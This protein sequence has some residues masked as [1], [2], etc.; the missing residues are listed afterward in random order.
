MKYQLQ[1]FEYV[2]HKHPLRLVLLFFI[3]IILS[4][5]PQISV[6]AQDPPPELE[7]QKVTAIYE[8]TCGEQDYQDTLEVW[9]VGAAGGE[10]YA[11]AV[12]TGPTCLTVDD[13]E[14]ILKASKTFYGTFSGG[15]NGIVKQRGNYNVDLQFVDGK[16][17]EMVG[18]DYVMIVQNPEAFTATTQDCEAKINL[19]SELKP[20][21]DIWMS[22]SY[23]DLDGVPI[24]SEKIISEA[25]IINGK[26]GVMLTTWDGEAMNIELQYTC[27]D[28]N[29]H[30]TNY[31]L[32]AYQEE[33]VQAP[34]QNVDVPP[35]EVEV[36]PEDPK[37]ASPENDNT[38]DNKITQ[39]PLLPIVVIVG[40]LAIG[41]AVL[42]GTG[43]VIFGVGKA[44]GIIGG[45]P[46]K[47][48]DS[49]SVARSTPQ[50][51]VA[52]K[53]IARPTPHISPSPPEPVKDLHP[54]YPKP[55]T[56]AEMSNLKHRKA[57]MEQAIEEY[58]HDWQE[59]NKK[60][61]RL[62]KMHKK[63]LIKRMLQLGL[64]TED[65]IGI[66][67][68]TDLVTKILSEPIEDAVGKPSP[69]KETEI[70]LATDKIIN[71]MKGKLEELQGNVRYLRTEIH[72]I[73]KNLNS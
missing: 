6:W 19:P 35:E 20:G 15:P 46:Q 21:D 55:L 8:G 23:T 38:G 9:N 42:L 44:T 68:P 72:N 67:N 34:D 39:S 59:T 37:Q 32:P 61:H 66:K 62:Q 27:P 31:V 16:R 48:M 60:L 49:K 47:P 22:A 73:N 57:E 24:A 5:F 63:N 58:K 54:D 4:S 7:P 1:K 65:I 28:G 2:N 33:V 41:G 52:P 70:L 43:A 14:P 13:G 25:W 29:A 40:I 18:Y 11:Q 30:T 69:E 71:N 50:N 10:E 36:L 26:A 3:L 51:P 12:L 45:D 64:E 17:V 56:E 53:P